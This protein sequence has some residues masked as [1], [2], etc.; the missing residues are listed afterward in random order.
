MQNRADILLEYIKYV[1]AQK[2]NQSISK[3][4]IIKDLSEHDL[5]EKEI[6][7]IIEAA[8]IG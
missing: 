8:N 2:V 5:S 4:E 1:I 3:E 7:F 6:E